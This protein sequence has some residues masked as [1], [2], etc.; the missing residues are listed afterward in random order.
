M[1]SVCVCV[2]VAEVYNIATSN[3]NKRDTNTPSGECGEFCLDHQMK[4]A[5]SIYYA[6]V[7][8]LLSTQ[9]H[10]CMGKFQQ[11]NSCKSHR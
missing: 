7:H 11:G 2:C 5:K 3:E 8:G 4:K 9:Y 10:T 1:A 6:N